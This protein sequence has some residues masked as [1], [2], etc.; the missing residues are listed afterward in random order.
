MSASAASYGAHARLL[1][2]SP[3]GTRR[4]SYRMP[5]LSIERPHHLAHAQAK[6]LAERLAR[7]F[8]Q[9]FALVWRWDDDVIRFQRPGVSGSMRV[10]PA[11][12]ALDLT[13]G[14]LFGAMKPVIERRINDE[15]DRLGGPGGPA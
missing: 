10:G 15:L 4:R 9:R 13:L 8:E 6:A 12:I 5:H 14:L 7:D 1:L 11:T 3:K 2:P